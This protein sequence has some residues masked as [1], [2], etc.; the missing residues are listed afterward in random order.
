MR[1]GDPRTLD[2]KIGDLLAENYSIQ[3]IADELNV[4]YGQVRQRYHVICAKL[5][6]R[7]DD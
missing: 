4:T 1:R 2:E 3:E 6:E 7:P 5:G